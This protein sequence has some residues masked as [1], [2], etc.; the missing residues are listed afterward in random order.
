[1][2]VLPTDPAGIAAPEALADAALEADEDRDA[3]ADETEAVVAREVDRPLEVALP[4][5]PPAPATAEEVVMPAEAVED[6][7][8]TTLEM[9][10]KVRSARS[11]MIGQRGR[12]AEA[13]EL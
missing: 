6:P 13:E 2:T 12:G 10:L 4:A 5:A 7:E 8:A 3:E 11:V 9:R 1:M